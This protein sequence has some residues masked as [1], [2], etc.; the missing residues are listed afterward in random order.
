MSTELAT[1][2]ENTFAAFQN[3]AAALSG[4]QKPILKFDKGDWY[5]G[6]DN[7]EMPT[8]TKLAADM[9]HAEWGW[10]RWKDGKPVDRKMVLVASGA[11]P[12]N[13]DDLGNL[14]EGLWDRDDQGK[15]RDP[16]QK[17]IEIP[18]REI[19]GEMREMVLSG[20]SRGY[21]GACKAL[22]KAFG[23]GMRTNMG[24]VPV[25]SL[26]GDKYQHKQYGMVKVPALPIVEWMDPTAKPAVEGPK[27]SKAKF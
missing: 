21:E 20:G 16:W 24:K 1:Y 17:M 25:I 14:D 26:S 13:R 18:V 15:P 10:V 5:A 9:L 12:A 3:A 7:E 22:F 4:D 2:N 19:S 8:G 27:S 11:G 23:E 6:Q